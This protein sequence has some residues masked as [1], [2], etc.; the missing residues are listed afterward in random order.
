MASSTWP[1]SYENTIGLGDDALVE[2]DE[3]GELDML[4]PLG[5]EDSVAEGEIDISPE[6]ETE[7][8]NDG[9]EEGD[10]LL[11]DAEGDSEEVLDGETEG[12]LEGDDD[13]LLEGNE[14]GRA[15]V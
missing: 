1:Q 9:L 4:G 13:G 6:G 11:G 7:G 12:L 2:G 3:V 5:D 15:H 8:L 10:L 14:I